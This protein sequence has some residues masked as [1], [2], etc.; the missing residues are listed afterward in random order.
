MK[1]II[2]GA[3]GMV[4][5][6]TLRECLLAPDVDEV[7]TVPVLSRLYGTPIEVVRVKNRFYVMAGDVDVEHDADR[8]DH[9]HGAHA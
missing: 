5:Q 7:V 8:H 6:G 3:T 4:G 2:F 1:V 9:A